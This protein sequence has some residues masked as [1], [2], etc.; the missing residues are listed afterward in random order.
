MKKLY[1]LLGLMFV[2]ASVGYAQQ[3]AQYTNYMFTIPAYNPGYVG[4]N[5][6]MCATGLFRSQWMGMST[7]TP[8]GKSLGVPMNTGL[9]MFDAPVR[10]LH[11][12]LGINAYYDQANFFKSTGVELMYSFHL[13]LG[14][15]I[16]GIGPKINFIDQRV[17]M[18]NLIGSQTDLDDPVLKEKSEKGQ[19]LFDL[20]VGAFY[21]VPQSFYVGLSVN[22]LIQSQAD[23]NDATT[24]TLKRM[25]WL[26]GGYEYELPFNPSFKLLPSVLFKTDFSS[27]EVEKTTKGKKRKGLNL[28]T[29]VSCLLEYD[30]KVWGG[31]SY[32]FQ[33]AV[34]LM[35]GGNVKNFK[36]GMSYDI[37]TNKLGLYS[38]G[39][40]SGS[41]EIF[42]RYCFKIKPIPKFTSH[43]NTRFL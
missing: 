30:N 1:I 11:G 28:T 26:T 42:V 3:E 22:R 5:G 35:M 8:D 32:R 21:K 18:E 10:V 16:L 24:Y 31:L 33:D 29:D 36:I 37:T 39:Q 15:G 9:F 23:Y 6:S 41:I 43:E 20:G 12:G 25:Y 38:K 17:D 7:N 40:S 4:L 27:T 14:D 2:A 13:N 34:I 19:M